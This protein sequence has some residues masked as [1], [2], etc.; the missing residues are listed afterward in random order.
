MLINHKRHTL[1][2][3]YLW[4]Q[5][6]PLLPNK[7]GHA[8]AQMIFTAYGDWMSENNAEQIMLL[9]AKLT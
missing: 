9:N 6:P 1:V 3:C 2:G 7:M 8:L 4:K 5:T